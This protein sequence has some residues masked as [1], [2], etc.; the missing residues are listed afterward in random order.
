VLLTVRLLNSEVLLPER[1]ASSPYQLEKKQSIE[2][3]KITKGEDLAMYH[4]NV[5]LTMSWYLSIYR[6]EIP[7]TER[8]EFD[9]SSFYLVPQDVLLDAENSTTYY[10]FV[11]RYLNKPFA[12]VKFKKY[13][14]EMPK[15]E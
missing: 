14:P 9:K 11:R 5:N 7:H 2:I 12:L 10:T 15:N 13:F 1:I 6:K 4:S 3:A 8:Y